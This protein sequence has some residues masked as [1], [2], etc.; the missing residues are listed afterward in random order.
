MFRFR[1]K[2]SLSLSPTA[3]RRSTMSR[4]AE[5]TVSRRQCGVWV[6]EPG[7]SSRPRS[8]WPGPPGIS[9][10]YASDAAGVATTLRLCPPD[11]SG[12]HSQG[13]PEETGCCRPPALIVPEIR[14]LIYNPSNM[15]ASVNSQKRWQI[16]EDKQIPVACGICHWVPG[17]TTKMASMAVRFGTRGL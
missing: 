14:R 6:W 7:G 17:C 15:R 16:K 9:M 13:G 12:P 1:D 11:F 10:K 5:K 2:R 8:K 3:P 4:L